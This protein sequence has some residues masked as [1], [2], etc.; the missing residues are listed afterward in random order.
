MTIRCL[1]H[2]P[3]PLEHLNPKGGAVRPTRMLA[4]FEQF[5]E[6]VVVSGTAAERKAQIAAV[7]RDVDA[8]AHFD[9]CYSE[10]STMPTL[11]TESHHLP[12]HPLLDF[13]FLRWLRTQGTPVGLFYRDIQW[14]VPSYGTGLNPLK[15]AFAQQMYRHDLREY[16]KC[17][18]ILFLPSVEMS[19][20]FPLPSGVRVE[21]LPPGHQIE[22][23]SEPHDPGQV[24]L[25]Y[26]GGTGDNYRLD[27]FLQAVHAVPQVQ[28]TL[29]T[30]EVE[31]DAVRERYQAWLGDNVTVVH[32]GAQDLAPLFA[33]ATVGVVAT[34]PQPY[35]RFAAPLKVY[36]YLGNGLPMIASQGSLAGRFVADHQLGW[37]EPYDAEAFTA[38]LRR[39]AA[40]P[41]LVTAQ[42]RHVLEARE[43][44]TWLSRAEQAAAQ[45]T[46][47]G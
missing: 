42:R 47:L 14:T 17:V 18:D 39:L 26:V 38:L 35:W 20:E 43:Q 4:A 5:C 12:T 31:W 9:F 21:A 33:D 40:D 28:L 22:Q 37:T 44:H 11:L 34:E 30:R 1:F 27:A 2:V 36:E 46:S 3:Y 24:R 10:S 7:K 45:L 6:V 8:G 29:C 23:P 32:V 41:G 13:G 16:A 19:T 15:R 25:F